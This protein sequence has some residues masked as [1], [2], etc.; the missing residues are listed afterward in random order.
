MEVDGAVDE[1]GGQVGLHFF[2]LGAGDGAL[3]G[4]FSFGFSVRYRDAL[5]F[6]GVHVVL[7]IYILFV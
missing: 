5:E 3:Q 4:V 1:G 2:E 7:V 6:Y